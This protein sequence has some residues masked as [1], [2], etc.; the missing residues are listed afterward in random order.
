MPSIWTKQAKFTLYLA[1]IWALLRG[2]SPLAWLEDTVLYYTGHEL[3]FLL[4]GELAMANM[5][6]RQVASKRFGIG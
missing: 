5:E 4:G 6:D 3:G 2:K 1:E